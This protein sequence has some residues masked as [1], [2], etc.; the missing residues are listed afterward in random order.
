[1]ADNLL[2]GI[3]LLGLATVAVFYIHDLITVLQLK[4][5]IKK[6]NQKIAEKEEEIKESRNE[7]KNLKDNYEAKLGRY[8]NSKHDDS[9]S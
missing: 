5:E 4:S 9:D 3:I 6:R 8:L 2:V 7:L 1:M